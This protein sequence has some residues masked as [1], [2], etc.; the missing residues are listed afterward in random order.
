M[1]L[2]VYHRVR[3]GAQLSAFSDETPPPRTSAKTRQSIPKGSSS[4]QQHAA[5]H[6]IRLD[7]RLI[8]EFKPPGYE[9]R[10]R[11]CLCTSHR[12]LIISSSRLV[13]RPPFAM[14]PRILKL[15]LHVLS[16]LPLP[17]SMGRLSQPCNAVLRSSTLEL[18][19]F[20]FSLC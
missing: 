9:V 19:S 6:G 11:A 1:S 17:N 18:P 8:C 4:Y 5:R 16:Q 10:P 12:H 15:K 14:M 20:R 7:L 3:T 2:R 13:A